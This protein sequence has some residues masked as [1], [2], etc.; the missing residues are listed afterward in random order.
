MMDTGTPGALSAAIAGVGLI[1][2]GMPDWPAASATLRGEAAY[3][4]SAAIIP[5]PLALPPAERRRTGQ[6]VRLALA[7]GFEAA[8]AAAGDVSRLATVFSSSGAD[9]DNCHAICEALASEDRQ[10]SPTRFHNSVHN[11]A[12]GY[13]GIA[14]GSMA[15][16]T[17][18]CTY[19]ATFAA[20]LLEAVTQVVAFARPVLVVACDTPYPQPLHAARPLPGSFGVA[21]LL[22]PDAGAASLARIELTLAHA[23]VDGMGDAA[24]ETLRLAIPAARSLPMLQLLAR[25]AAARI[26][27][28]YL[29]D[30][31]LTVALGR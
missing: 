19:D 16:S 9:G 10:I 24:L 8:R 3:V 7:V 12:S 4:F 22:A 11:A 21:L 1:G 5:V 28:D 31:Q 23:P 26:A 15:P 25:G 29:P 2:P 27:L 20:G 17:S 30:L 14:S 13:W 18:I 6:I